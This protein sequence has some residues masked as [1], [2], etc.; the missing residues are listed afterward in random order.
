MRLIIFSISLILPFLA[1]SQVVNINN[2]IQ[3]VAD[4]TVNL[5]VDNGGLK[6][7]GTFIHDSSTVIFSGAGVTAISGANPITFYNLTFRG[8]GTKL[9]E[10]NT[11]VVEGL[12]VENTSVLDADGASNN[13]EFTLKSSD[14]ATAFV[15]PL[16]T[17]SITGNVTVERF[18]NTGTDPGEHG[19]SWQFLATPTTGQTVYQSWQEGGATPSG[20]GTRITGI[21]TGF[22]APSPFPAMK[23]YDPPTN[24]WTGIPGTNIPLY[25]NKGY[26][27][28]VRGDRT[29][30]AYNAAPNNTN[31]R[32][33]GVLHTPANPP[34]PVPVPANLFQSFGNPYA[35]R[36]HFNN[37]FTIST[38]IQNAYHAWDPLLTGT[39]GLGGYQTI[40]AVAGYMP[41]AGNATAYYPAGVAAPYIE[42]GQAVF[43]QGTATGGNVNFNETVKVPGSRLVHRGNADFPPGRQFLFTS[44]LTNSGQIADGNIVAFEPGLG[45]EIN[46][47]DAFK[48]LNQGENFGLMRNGND[49]SVEARDPAVLTDTI[50]YHFSN[51][52]P[53]DY[54]LMIVPVNFS[55]GLQAYFVDRASGYTSELSLA[56]TNYVTIN[57]GAAETA[58]PDRY[59]IVFR[60]GNVVP[61][62]F[63]MVSAYRNNDQ[64]NQV[65][66]RVENE[67]NL[68]EYIVEKSS[69][70]LYFTPV[71]N[72]DPVHNNGGN[73]SY[74]FQDHDPFAITYYRIKAV[75]MD[76]QVQYSNIVKVAAMMY[77]GISVFPNP[78]T[79]NRIMVRFSN[80]QAG[81]YGL[82][83]INSIGQKVYQEYITISTSSESH[84]IYPETYLST[85][86]YNFVISK[87]GGKTQT[88]R[89]VVR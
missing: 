54:N 11:S 78:V 10:G 61:V 66:W 75:S 44:L 63:V 48:I 15:F 55:A 12:A 21:G 25:N 16:T 79:D 64:T 1:Q 6:N 49:L 30:V 33:K 18:I 83:I 77:S 38:G 89:I 26:M 34:A 47:L 42:S 20:Y 13:R 62:R 28:F 58:I 9:N 59:I 56:D 22:D 43:V 32:S 37:I 80:Q 17:G 24:T 8:S 70:G 67:I 5:V 68:R 2:G 82:S 29:V 4:G 7:D 23:I 74:N 3:L 40:S 57:P 19:K 53:Q 88:E 84:T 76:G 86:T 36:V 87:P 72:T 31:M 73:A 52:R 45:N 71:G 51:L 14:S 81:R 65:S 69:E 50:F 85:G 41:T 39:F 35:S 27:L 60:P 46:D